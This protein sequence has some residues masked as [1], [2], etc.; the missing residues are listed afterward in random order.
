MLTK[1]E[2]VAQTLVGT[3]HRKFKTLEDM[4]FWF[5]SIKGTTME[6]S[7]VPAKITTTIEVL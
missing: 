2:Y 4:N 6:H 5:H 3:V 7:Y 1:I